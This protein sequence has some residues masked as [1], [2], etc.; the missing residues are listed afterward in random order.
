MMLAGVLG[1]WGVGAF[2]QNAPL[3]LPGLSGAAL[4]LILALYM[5]RARWGALPDP[6][7]GR[8]LVAGLVLYGAVMLGVA[9]FGV[10]TYAPFIGLY[11]GGCVILVGLFGMAVRLSRSSGEG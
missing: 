10:L 6:V 9:A 11:P 7:L 1:L 5:D 3:T 8:I 4:V 2:A